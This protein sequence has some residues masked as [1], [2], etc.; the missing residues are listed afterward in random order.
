M[1]FLGASKIARFLSQNTELLL[2]AVQ[3]DISEIYRGDVNFFNKMEASSPFCPR[4][5]KWIVVG[6]TDSSSPL[7][8]RVARLLIFAT[9]L[10]P[11]KLL[12]PDV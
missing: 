2:S 1:K 12:N 6:Q 4:Y 7:F 3:A 9:V 10:L 5:V 8:S 11:R